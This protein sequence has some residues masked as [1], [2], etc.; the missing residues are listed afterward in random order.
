MKKILEGME[1]YRFVGITLISV[2]VFLMLIVP[3]ISYADGNTVSNPNKFENPLKPGNDSLASF[4][5]TILNSVV[6]PIGAIICAF[7]IIYA[8]FLFV[9]ARGN[10]DKLKDAKSALLNAV[11]GTAILLGAAA[12]ST[13]ISKTIDAIVK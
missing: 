8:G 6:M 10:E 2:F 7:F 4:V 13:I 11:I 1:K 12:I 3:I 9:T 5:Q